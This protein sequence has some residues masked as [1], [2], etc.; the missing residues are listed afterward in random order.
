MD[1][2]TWGLMALLAAAVPAAANAGAQTV[3]KCEDGDTVRYTDQPC[4][5]GAVPYALPGVVVM[6][7]PTSVEKNLADQ[8]DERME[9][10]RKAG[11]VVNAKWLEAYRGFRDHKARVRKAI[12]E[13]RVI[14]GMTMRE[15]KSALG[16]PDRM[17]KSESHGSHKET[18]IYE[19]DGARRR[20]NFKNGE[21]S[22]ASRRE[23]EI[24]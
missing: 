24:R 5:A 11:G 8:Y 13:N 1:I 23:R 16:E 3:Y 9:R 19:R 14:R 18:W 4:I 10:E 15:V 12:I 21:V 20:V 7:A 6:A 2:K 22:T 17:Q